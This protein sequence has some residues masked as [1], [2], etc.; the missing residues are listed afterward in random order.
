MAKPGFVYILLCSNDTLYTGST[1]DLER[2]IEEHISGL[3]VNYTKK[4]RPIE[5]LYTEKYVHVALAFK[6]E[7]QIQGW[8]QPKKWA[9]VRG[10]LEELH[11]LSICTNPTHHKNCLLEKGVKLG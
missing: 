6:R 7:E 8:S 1:I 4:Y 11:D 3:G 2:S 5:L 10:D 9:L